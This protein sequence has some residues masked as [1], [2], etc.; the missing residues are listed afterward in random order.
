ML[1]TGIQVAPAGQPMPQPAN[2]GV[3]GA[4]T[5]AQM[6]QQFA[7]AGA[8][9]QPSLAGYPA[10]A[11]GGGTVAAMPNQHS[12]DATLSQAYSGIAQY[13][14]TCRPCLVCN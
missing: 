12:I 13:T 4:L 1:L 2:G 5:A 14:G 3:N 7:V 11:L 10:H 6:Q 8:P 9:V